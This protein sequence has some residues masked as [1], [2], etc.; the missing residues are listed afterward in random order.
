MVFIYFLLSSFL[1]CTMIRFDNTVLNAFCKQQEEEASFSFL[2][3]ISLSVSVWFC[4]SSLYL[5][6]NVVLIS[7][8][9]LLR[10]LRHIN[11]HSERERER[12]RERE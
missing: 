7:A 2:L 12:E 6:P 5:S 11:T 3:L 4:L 10:P 1:Q 9:R 8:K